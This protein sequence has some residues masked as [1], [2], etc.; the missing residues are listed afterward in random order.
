[1][2]LAQ[3]TILTERTAINYV[4]QRLNDV[5][6]LK[7]GH[8][9]PFAVMLAA[10]VYSE[11]RDMPDRHGRRNT[12]IR[13]WPVQPEIVKALSDAFEILVNAQ[14]RS[15]IRVLYA[16]DCSGSMQS[17]C[18]GTP[19]RCDK[20]GAAMIL[21]LGRPQTNSQACL[22]TTY[23]RQP[24]PITD[25]LTINDL[26]IG[27]PEGTDC[28]SPIQYAYE[29]NEK[30]DAIVIYTDNETWY[31]NK[32]ATT[33]FQQYKQKFNNDCKLIVCAMAATNAN[34]VDPQD[35]SQLGIVGLDGNVAMLINSFIGAGQFA[36]ADVDEE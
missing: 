18:I 33:V 29:N 9:H 8:V 11:G 17:P 32:H 26:V 20:A 12:Q 1:V 34:I 24:R 28:S 23:T 22:F 10:F 15:D 13:S 6:W 3:R 21:A 19:V 30:Y 35:P 27:T 5:N 16:L 4:V 2:R 25:R 14:P 7:K 31:G 36:L